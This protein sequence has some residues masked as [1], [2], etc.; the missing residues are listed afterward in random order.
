MGV[1]R[2]VF[3]FTTMMALLYAGMPFD[4]SNHGITQASPAGIHFVCGKSGALKNKFFDLN[5]WNF[6]I[7]DQKIFLTP[8]LFILILLK[9]R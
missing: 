1:S 7:R 2:E 4:I 6:K 8:H 9:V 3:Y 5:F